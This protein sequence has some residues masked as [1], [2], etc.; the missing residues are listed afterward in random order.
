MGN[1]YD[2]T[3]KSAGDRLYGSYVSRYVTIVESEL[4]HPTHDPDLVQKGDPV[5]VNGKAMVG[6]AC[7]SASADTDL[8]TIDTE[9]IFALMVTAT[10]AIVIGDKIMITVATAAL[11]N[12]IGQ[13]FGW[14]LSTLTGGETSLVAVKVH[15]AM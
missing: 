5:S 13:W 11:T 14:A 6:V 4:T 3:G 1:P 8:I 9:G 15:G 10:G 7:E 12:T 2:P